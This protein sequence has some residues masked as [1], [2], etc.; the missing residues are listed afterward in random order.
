V[1]LSKKKAGRRMVALRPSSATCSS[2]VIHDLRK[3]R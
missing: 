2:R 3:M 1:R